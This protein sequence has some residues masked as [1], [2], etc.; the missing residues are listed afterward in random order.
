MLQ[1]KTANIVLSGAYGI[2]EGIAVDTHV[3]RLSNLL[4]ITKDQDP[5]KIEKDLMAA[6]PKDNW[7]TLSHLLI[8]HGRKNL[9]GKKTET[10]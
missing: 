2:N 9:P 4:G 7:G 3:K 10:Q 6:T 5:V 1:E 8:Y